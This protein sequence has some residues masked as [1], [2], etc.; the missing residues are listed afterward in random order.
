MSCQKFVTIWLQYRFRV[1]LIRKQ[2]KIVCG[3]QR[4]QLYLTG[5]PHENKRVT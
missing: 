2:I 4:A 5:G 3:V 1:Q